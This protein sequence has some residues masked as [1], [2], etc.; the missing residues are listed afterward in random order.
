MFVTLLIGTLFGPLYLFRASPFVLGQNA[1]SLFLLVLDRDKS[2]QTPT[3]VQKLRRW[4][5]AER[6]ARSEGPVGHGPPRLPPPCSPHCARAIAPAPWQRPIHG[7][8]LGA[9]RGNA[10]AVCTIRGAI[11]Q[12]GERVVRIDEVRS[13]IL[14][15]S[16]T[17]Q[18]DRALERPEYLQTQG[19]RPFSLDRPLPFPSS[20]L[21]RQADGQSTGAIRRRPLRLPLPTVQPGGGADRSLTGRLQFTPE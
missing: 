13:S 7:A 6:R 21:A 16:T 19:F 3:C 18:P 15:G 1:K 20:A 10:H 8:R 12:L 11:A 17:I 5:R 14:L 9:S 2:S 4:P